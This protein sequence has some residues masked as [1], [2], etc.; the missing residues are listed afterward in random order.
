MKVDITW[1]EVEE[2]ARI[3]NAAGFREGA[4]KAA[5]AAFKEA[6]ARHQGADHSYKT[7]YGDGCCTSGRAILD[8]LPA[9][10]EVK[11]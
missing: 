7:G 6:D 2:R 9:S 10:E 5:K 11:G 1:P 8:L 4:E 3:A